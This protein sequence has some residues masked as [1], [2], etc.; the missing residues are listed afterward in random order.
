VQTIG[1]AVKATGWSP[2]YLRNLEEQG[3]I[4]P[5]ARET[6]GGRRIYSDEDIAAL[7]AIKTERAARRAARAAGADDGAEVAA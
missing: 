3:L 6:H 2:T 7:L 1:G 4:G 5:I